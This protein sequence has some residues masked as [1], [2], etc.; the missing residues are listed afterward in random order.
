M[1]DTFRLLKDKKLRHKERYTS[2]GYQYVIADN[3]NFLKKD[4]WN[5]ITKNKSVFMSIDYL[6]VLDAYSPE[7]TEQR[8]ALAYQEG[9]PIAAFVFQIAVIGGEQLVLPDKKLKEQVIK[10][11]QERVLVCGNLVSNG[12]HGLAF[13]DE[14]SIEQGWRIAAEL[15]YRIRRGEKINGSVNFAIVKDFNEN[16]LEASMVMERYSYRK[17]QTDPD[18]VLQLSQNCDSF[19]EYLQLLT[20]KYRNRIKKV[21]KTLQ[22]ANITDL[23]IVD[24]A[25]YEAIIH[26]LYLQVEERAEVR[27][28][29]LPKGYFSALADALDEGFCCSIIKLNN[30]VVGFV[31]TIKDGD[32]AKG[33]Y[34]GFDAQINQTFPIYFRLLQLVVEH[35]ISMGC[36]VISFGRTA[37]EPKTGLGAKPSSTFVWARHRLPSVNFIVRKLFRVIPYEEAPDRNAFKKLEG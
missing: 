13:S 28:A 31:T 1:K 19:D 3:I 12:L 26:R 14:L 29:T 4:D 24:L 21:I 10:R 22:Q 8:Y 9:K 17:I 34:V 20:S 37:S 23:R 15:M 30:E 2:L 5:E 25:P 16:E 35:G 36:Q 32:I 7:N 11:Y 18:M 33:Y 6:R 27:P